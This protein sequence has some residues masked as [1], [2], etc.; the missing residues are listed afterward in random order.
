MP[1]GMMSRL[2][3]SL[4]EPQLRKLPEYGKL[5]FDHLCAEYAQLIAQRPTPEE[6]A[7]IDRIK[8]ARAN[9]ALAW[10][11][12]YLFEQI[13]VRYLSLS[14]LKR[15]IKTLR[16]QFRN[17]AGAKD[18]DIYLASK[19][20][21]LDTETNDL[22]LRQDCQFLLN[23]FYLRYALMSAREHMRNNLLKIA[24]FLAVVT[25]LV[26]AV[27]TYV[28]FNPALSDALG[29]GYGV[30]TLAV[31]MFAGI[32]GALI[33]MQQRI[34]AASSEGDPIYLFSMLTHGRF[35]IFLSPISGAVFSVA[36]YLMFTGGLLSGKIFP[37][38][39]TVGGPAPVAT[40]ATA[41]ASPAATATASPTSK[42]TPSASPTISPAATASTT[43][44]P[45]ASPT[46]TTTTTPSVAASPT[47]SAV[48]TPTASPSPTPAPAEPVFLN[49]FLKDTGPATGVDYALLVIWAFIAGFAERFVPDALN[50]LVAN[51][52]ANPK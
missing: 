25:I 28:N 13:L 7:D 1:E 23:E 20:P 47:A 49:K 3:E 42:L 24:A 22:L 30:T 2:T 48:A 38:I 18:F 14:G 37:T 17:I 33:S 51:N 15:K 4:Y 19:P 12:I 8:T 10:K 45:V 5:L 27:F 32:V 16:T 31:V 41:T 29:W 21:D 39:T 9:D 6:R 35:G 40:A 50:R 26:G 46:M 44:S 36:L 43:P 52:A 34:Q 11:D